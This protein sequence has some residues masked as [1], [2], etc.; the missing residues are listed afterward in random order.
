[1]IR[2]LYIITFILRFE[3][4][5]CEIPLHHN[6]CRFFDSYDLKSNLPTKR[7]APSIESLKTT[8]LRTRQNV[9]NI[10]FFLFYS[11]V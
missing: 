6:V 2:L 3:A 9:K 5:M 1:M 11:V 7:W 4:A 8:D 10:L